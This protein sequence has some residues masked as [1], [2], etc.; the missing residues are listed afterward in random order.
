ML[1]AHGIVG[2]VSRRSSPGNTTGYPG[3]CRRDQIH[4]ARN[5]LITGQC[6]N[7]TAHDASILP[8]HRRLSKHHRRGPKKVPPIRS[9][10]QAQTL[11]ILTNNPS[12]TLI[13]GYDHWHLTISSANEVFADPSQPAFRSGRA[14][15]C[16]LRQCCRNHRVAGTAK[17]TFS[18][19]TSLPVSIV[20]VYRLMPAANDFAVLHR[21]SR[22]T[23]NGT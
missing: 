21:P 15:V 17:A 9:A 5:R 11:P 14:P 3:R 19:R 23:S 7:A 6:S 20:Y 12:Q 13:A 4:N 1:T 16:R 8:A 18:F 10:M 22:R 2:Y